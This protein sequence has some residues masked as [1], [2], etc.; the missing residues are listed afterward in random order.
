M[1]APPKLGLMALQS[2]RAV[3]FGAVPGGQGCIRGQLADLAVS[4]NGAIIIR[5]GCKDPPSI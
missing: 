3:E 1:P 2:E 4:P 5:D